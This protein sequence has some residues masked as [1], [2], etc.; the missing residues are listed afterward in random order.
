MAR[1]DYPIER[2]D[3]EDMAQ[4]RAVP[5]HSML[6]MPAR[7]GRPAFPAHRVAEILYWQK[8]EGQISRRP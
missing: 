8:V 6:A 4:L 7:A 3:L 1:V 5:R 2:M